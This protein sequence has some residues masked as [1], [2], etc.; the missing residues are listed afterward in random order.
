MTRRPS[1]SARG[2]WSLVSRSPGCRTV[3][4]PPKWWSI[5]A[6]RE[7]DVS[8]SPFPSGNSGG[9]GAVPDAKTSDFRARSRRSRICAES[10]SCT[11]HKEI[12]RS[13][14]R[15]PKSAVFGR[16]LARLSHHIATAARDMP[17]SAAF[18]RLGVLDVLSSTTPR[19]SGRK[20]NISRHLTGLATRRGEKGGLKAF[21]RPALACPSAL[22]SLLT[23]VLPEG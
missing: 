9:N 4:I 13:T 16:E 18:S 11:P 10:Y 6:A 20:R 23:E 8:P 22:T 19:P 12:R 1:I 3:S 5:P 7:D 21:M 14:P 17:Q 2:S 15:L